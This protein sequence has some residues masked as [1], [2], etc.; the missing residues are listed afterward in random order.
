MGLPS[1][2]D[3]NNR[4]RAEHTSTVGTATLRRALSGSAPV[5]SSCIRKLV[6]AACS[7]NVYTHSPACISRLCGVIGA[8][9]V[10]D[11][12]AEAPERA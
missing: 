2:L 7:D 12:A 9:G 4:S 8:S 6:Q 1:Y 3:G 11:S 5:R 10:L